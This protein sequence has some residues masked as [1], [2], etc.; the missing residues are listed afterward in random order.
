MF[1]TSLIAI[2]GL[3]L[4]QIIELKPK[5]K[6]EKQDYRKKLLSGYVFQVGFVYY[7]HPTCYCSTSELVKVP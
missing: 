6:Y 3:T 1:V 4:F 2:I 5:E 7:Q